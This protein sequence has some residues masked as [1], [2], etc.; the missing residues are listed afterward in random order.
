MAETVTGKL[1]AAE[2]IAF[3]KREKPKD[4][5]VAAPPS[6]RL[7]ALDAL[8]GVC[9]VAMIAL[10]AVGPTAAPGRALEPS[11]LLAA[12]FLFCMGMAIP[13]SLAGRAAR[14]SRGRL[15]LHIGL[16][17]LILVA[18]GIV[19]TNAPGTDL[20]QLIIPGALQFAGLCYGLTAL[21][22][23]SIGRKS[24]ADFSLRLW[25]VAA[26]AAMLLVLYAGYLLAQPYLPGVP[27]VSDGF[28]PL[29]LMA[30]LGGSGVALLGVLVALFVRKYGVRNVVAGLAF[31]GA[32]LLVA[33]GALGGVMAVRGAAWTPT[34]ALVAGGMAL[35]A[36]AVMAIVTEIPGV[37]RG[38]YPLRVFGANALVAF[39]AATIATRLWPMTPA[40]A[41]ALVA[42][43]G[44]PL[45]ALFARRVYLTP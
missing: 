4:K 11:Q 35:I 36:F 28:D 41:G 45:W 16:R 21:L 44:L 38:A 32:V 26:T 9:V 23:L 12:G 7:E 19:I 22:C 18:V 37:R 10:T 20:T 15:M 14:Q 42:V 31:L 25:P 24:D 39:A 34:F 1:M 3:R 27:S 13:L 17:T 30:V 40:Y 8:R 5:P 33:G 43:I 6:R 29:S 2:I